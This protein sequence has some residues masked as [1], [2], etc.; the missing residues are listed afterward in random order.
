[1]SLKNIIVGGER[2]SMLQKVDI[3]SAALAGLICIG[4]AGLSIAFRPL[5]RDEYWGLFSSDPSIGLEA[6]V[7]DR[8]VRDVHPPLYL[9]L[10]YG[11]R[12]FIEEPLVL[13]ALNIPVLAL[14]ALAAWSLSSKRD[15]SI[16]FFLFFSLTSYWAI[17]FVAEIRPYSL[18]YGLCMVLTIATVEISH[19]EGYSI[20]RLAAFLLI[21][22]V[23]G[24]LH[25][26][27]ALFVAISGLVLGVSW[28]LRGS[29]LRF[30]IIGIVSFAAILPAALWLSFSLSD[31]SIY[32]GPA[33]SF[34]ERLEYG[35]EQFLRGIF[36][37]TFGSNLAFTVL[38]ILGVGIMAR[39]RDVGMLVL[40]AAICGTVTSIFI[41]HAFWT[42]MI[43]ER[44][45][46]VIMPAVIWLMQEAARSAPF[47]KLTRRLI[48][49]IPFVAMIT[50]FLFGAEYFKDRE[51]LGEVRANYRLFDSCDEA[52]IYAFFRSFHH[53]EFYPYLT[54][55][56]LT[57][58][59]SPSG[60][61]L[62]A[63]NHAPTANTPPLQRTCAIK[64]VAVGLRRGDESWRR[65]ARESM[66]AA[67]LDLKR[68]EEIQLAEGR[69]LLFVARESDTGS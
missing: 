36:V 33:P 54:R 50:P 49:A 2:P 47:T 31:I 42:P 21:G 11:L 38:A 59:P 4:I 30:V 5:W 1:M 56:A 40:F 67:G 52:E 57:G 53:P 29:R 7:T 25:Y 24:I 51:Q 44:A 19:S 27:A 6:L 18:I 63:V 10:L 46:I 65:Q 66:T 43:K 62:I 39:R 22:A 58:S 48:I 3:R 37:K 8:L 55:T 14:S 45:F 35:A 13:R 68:L 41:L 69:H 60:P 32:S 34:F 17:F 20:K 61:T 28:L 64:G 12:Q 9:L 16:Q 15:Q 23:L 26:F